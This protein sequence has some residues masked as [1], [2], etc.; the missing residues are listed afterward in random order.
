[1]FPPL[2][3]SKIFLASVFLCVPGSVTVFLSVVWLT[4]IRERVSPTLP[5][6]G[7]LVCLLIG[8][9]IGL[10][11]SFVVG[12][13]TNLVKPFWRWPLLLGSTIVLTVFEGFLYY[14]FLTLPSPHFG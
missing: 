13:L 7:L 3:Q 9:I 11:K 5:F 2:H 8:I 4:V 1:M 14:G 6:A 10:I 12:T